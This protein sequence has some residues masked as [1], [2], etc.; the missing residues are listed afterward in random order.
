M[1][2]L[3]NGCRLDKICRASARTCRALR[4]PRCGQEGDFALPAARMRPAFF[5]GLTNALPVLAGPQRRIFAMV[6]GACSCGSRRAADAASRVSMSIAACRAC[7]P[8]AQ[9]GPSHRQHVPADARELRGVVS[10]P[11]GSV[12]S[13]QPL[14]AFKPAIGKRRKSRCKSRICIVYMSV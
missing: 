12:P 13:E 14:A 10:A 6:P 8:A 2:G 7:V 11:R 1:F 5:A 3:R 4:W 9:G